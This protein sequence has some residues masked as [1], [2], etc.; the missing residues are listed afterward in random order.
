MKTILSG[1]ISIVYFICHCHLFLFPMIIH[2]VW[3][4][5]MGTTTLTKLPFPRAFVDAVLLSQMPFLPHSCVLDLVRCFALA[6][7][8]P[9]LKG[10]LFCISILAKAVLLIPI[11]LVVYS[12]ALC[13]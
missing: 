4:S 3:L 5:H 7:V 1:T 8:K 13:S 12:K 6:K 11:S 9:E 10:V 2:V